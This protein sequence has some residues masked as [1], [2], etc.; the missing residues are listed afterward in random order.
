MCILF[1][2]KWELVTILPCFRL[3]LT[4]MPFSS[5]FTCSKTNLKI[6][7]L[8]FRFRLLQTDEENENSYSQTRIYYKCK[9]WY[10]IIINC[11]WSCVSNSVVKKNIHVYREERPTIIYIA[12][13][14]NTCGKHLLLNGDQ[15]NL[16]RLLLKYI[17][18]TFEEKVVQ[19]F[20]PENLRI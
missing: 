12:Y 13:K 9:C 8:Y 1:M 11:R 20:S 18:K 4:D 14:Q 19:H 2:Y 15:W 3:N 5:H 17:D 7:V 10:V 6:N 16:G